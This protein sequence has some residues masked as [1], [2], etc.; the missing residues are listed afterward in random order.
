VGLGIEGK[1]TKIS[2]WNTIWNILNA[3][4]SQYIIN[5]KVVQRLKQNHTSKTL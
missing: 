3:N 1:E 5:V 4:S 2:L